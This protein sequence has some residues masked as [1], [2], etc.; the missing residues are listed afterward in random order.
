MSRSVTGRVKFACEVLRQ[1]LFEPMTGVPQKPKLVRSGG[2][3]ITF[4]GHSSFLIQIAGKNVLVD[5][6]FAHWLVLLRRM[7]RPGVDVSDLPPVDVVLQTHAHM[8]HLNLPSLRAI[9]EHNE[10]H[11]RPLPEIVVPE[12]VEDLVDSLGFARVRTLGWWDELRLDG[13]HVVM[14]PAQH[15]GT[16]YF[17]DDHRGYGGYVL[18]GD[19]HSVYHSGD[20][21]YF[22]GFREVARLRPEVALLPI[23]AYSPDSIRSVHTTPEDAL[24]AFFDVGAARMIPMHYGTFRLS[25]E[26][27]EE[28]LPRLLAAAAQRG[29][30]ERIKVL[31]EGETLLTPAK[32][33]H[34]QPP[35]S[36]A[37][38]L[39]MAL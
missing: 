18:E 29:A 38:Q 39:S 21:A 36:E 28:P 32:H 14:T 9:L 17:H 26:P 35:W 25:K 7:R 19:G 24:Q 1:S 34:E 27:L 16:R 5:P 4:I 15:W 10:R 3:G 12:G 20:T 37:P 11:S 6:V 8:D 33:G 22:E 31:R 2:L 30:Q 23:G 13:L